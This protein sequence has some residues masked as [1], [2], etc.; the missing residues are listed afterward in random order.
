MDWTTT[1]LTSLLGVACVYLLVGRLASPLKSPVV[2]AIGFFAFSAAYSMRFP[3]D[4]VVAKVNRALV[5]TLRETPPAS[6]AA[7]LAAF[8]TWIHASPGCLLD[9]CWT[10]GDSD[11]ATADRK[12]GGAHLRSSLFLAGASSLEAAADKEAASK[13][14]G[15]GEEVAESGPHIELCRIICEPDARK[16]ERV[17]LPQVEGDYRRMSVSRHRNAEEVM[18]ERGRGGEGGSDDGGPATATATGEGRGPVGGSASASASA[19]A[20]HQLS[21]GDY[22]SRAPA[23]GANFVNSLRRR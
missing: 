23:P 19:S 12:S 5:D 6:Y 10:R 18:V 11:S 17:S 14:P 4:P 7:L 1:L 21:T 20:S 2:G 16:W 8:F 3:G 13:P 22:W 9:L 15:E